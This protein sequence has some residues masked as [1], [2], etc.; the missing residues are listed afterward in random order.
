MVIS[1]SAVKLAPF[2]GEVIFG[3]P[4]DGISVIVILVEE[5]T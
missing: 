2:P 4:T 1:S 5:L 3:T